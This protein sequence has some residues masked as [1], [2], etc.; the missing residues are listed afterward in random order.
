[1]TCA[2]TSEDRAPVD[3]LDQ[4]VAERGGVVQLLLPR[5]GVA[6]ERDDAEGRLRIG[7]RLIQATD[8]GE[9]MPRL[10]ERRPFGQRRSQRELERPLRS[11][12]ERDL[13]FDRDFARAQAGAQLPSTLRVEEREQ[14]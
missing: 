5:L 12:R 6:F 8:R 1:S 14:Q 4:V 13:A 10:D 7:R 9:E 2:S 3:D 11:G